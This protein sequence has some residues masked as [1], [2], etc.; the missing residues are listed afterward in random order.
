MFKRHLRS[1]GSAI[2][3]SLFLI[4]PDAGAGAGGAGAAGAASSDGGGAGGGGGS[5]GSGAGS[6][7]AAPVKLTADTLVDLGDGQPA[8]WGEL[9]AG[10]KARFMPRENYDRGVKFLETEAQRLQRLHD[11]HVRGQQQ[12]PLQREAPRDPF[13]HVRG[14]PMV[15]GDTVAQ[16]A[17]DL[18]KQGLGPIAQVVTSL[19]TKIKDLETQLGETRQSLA[20]HQELR[21]RGEFEHM[22]SSTIDKLTAIKGLPEGGKIDAADPFVKELAEDL[23]LSYEPDSWKPGDYDKM[24]K[25]RIEGAIAFVRKLDQAALKNAEEIRRKSF[26]PNVAR[27]GG[28]GSGAPKYQHETGA[29]IAARAREAGMFRSAA[30]T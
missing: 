8:R 5:G 10:E 27:G 22:V 14:R 29:S 19:A 25:G 18:Y 20:P 21:A 15:D 13:S 11:T 23:H 26:F 7:G 28:Q 2:V 16:I 12:R 6:G 1:W 24:L 30:N 3:D 4:P 9:T 17:D